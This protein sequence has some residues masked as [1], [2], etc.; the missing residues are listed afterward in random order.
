M[1]VTLL[2][3][4]FFI[5]V[6]ILLGLTTWY[7]YLRNQVLGCDN[8]PNIWCYN[9]WTC[10]KVPGPSECF[11]NGG[12]I[13]D[14]GDAVSPPGLYNCLMGPQSQS[15]NFCAI[16]KTDLCDCKLNSDQNCYNGCGYKLSQVPPGTQCATLN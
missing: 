12:T 5:L 15:A 3:I 11:L 16:P 13:N 6:V 4:V 9:D 1:N 10:P 7:L 14:K 2:M 8:D